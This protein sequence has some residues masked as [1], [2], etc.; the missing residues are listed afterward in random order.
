VSV[1]SEFYIFLFRLFFWGGRR[2]SI[3]P[4]GRACL[5]SLVF[6]PTFR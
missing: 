3:R 6:P 4:K 2:A 1:Y 5:S